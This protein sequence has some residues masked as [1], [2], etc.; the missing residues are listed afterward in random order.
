[1]CAR[2]TQVKIYITSCLIYS[3]LQIYKHTVLAFCHFPWKKTFEECR[4]L[5]D[6]TVNSEIFARTLFSRNFA[7]V[8]IKPWRNGKIT[9]SFIDTGK[10]CLNREIFH[11]TYVSFNAICENKVIAK[12]SKYTVDKYKETVCISNLN[13][14]FQNIVDQTCSIS[15]Y[16]LVVSSFHLNKICVTESSNKG[17]SKLYT[18][19]FLN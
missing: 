19:H 16:I 4:L 9:L 12:T 6:N 13:F 14:L 18:S 17:I 3:R 5:V 7:F 11:I 15:A 10:S 1:M 2:P 8:K